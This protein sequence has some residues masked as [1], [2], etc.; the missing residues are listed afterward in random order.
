VVVMKAETNERRVCAHGCWCVVGP[1][2]MWV[3]DRQQRAA[4]S[5]PYHLLLCSRL[6]PWWHKEAP[7]G[8]ESDLPPRPSPS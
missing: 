3:A 4:T 1:R 5:T 2:V 8:Q 7:K 6:H